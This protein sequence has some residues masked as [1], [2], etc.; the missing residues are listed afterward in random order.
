MGVFGALFLISAFFI[1]G[2]LLLF[3]TWGS[4]DLTLWLM[5]LLLYA[6]SYV[7]WRQLKKEKQQA[8][9]IEAGQWRQG[10]FIDDHAILYVDAQRLCILLPRE[11][12]ATTAELFTTR[13]GGSGGYQVTCIRYWVGRT[14]HHLCFNEE[15]AMTLRQWVKTGLFY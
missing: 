8:K 3:A 4:A 11:Y 9:Q 6:L 1:G 12:L 13:R 2:S 14:A 5:M 7:C 15:C 10:F